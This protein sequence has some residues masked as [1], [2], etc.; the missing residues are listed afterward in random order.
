MG[1]IVKTKKPKIIYT[2]GT[3]DILNVGHLLLLEKSK[4]LGDILIVGVST[5]ALVVSYKKTKP[6]ISYTDRCKIVAACKYVDRVIKQST[7]I[8][9]RVLK[10]YNVDCITIGSDWEKIYLE[11][12]EWMKQNG[13]VV[14]L[15]YT[16][17][18][19]TTE[20]K[21]KI[22]LNSYSIIKAE[23]SREN[24]KDIR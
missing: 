4:A 16:K 15:P 12:L 9:I 24:I 17:T 21:R 19:S 20:I 7:L 13:S 3:F 22:I 14:Y 5:D 10:K 8:D 6:I 2:A 23:L 11:G 18:I 1:L